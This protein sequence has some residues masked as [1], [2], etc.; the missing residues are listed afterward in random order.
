M[1]T[2][3]TNMAELSGKVLEEPK[4]S[5]SIYGESFFTFPLEV[6]RLSGHV[7]VLPVILSEKLL[8]RTGIG[9]G[10]RIG[11][12][13]QLRSYNRIIEGNSRLELKIFAKEM[14]DSPEGECINQMEM[15]GFLCK[16]PIYRTTPFG[17]EITDM[18]VAVNRSYNKS[19][20]IP[21][22]AWGRNARMAKNLPVGQKIRV[23]GRIQSREYEKLL[24]SGERIRRVAYEVSAASLLLQEP[25]ARE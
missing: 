9:E 24:E 7:D 16:P 23:E 17:R 3:E 19:D 13:G 1:I 25:P 6:P 21:T 10:A 2:N 20:Y 8:A 14:Y 12:R 15:T 5:H 4:P 18:L 22:I 11:L